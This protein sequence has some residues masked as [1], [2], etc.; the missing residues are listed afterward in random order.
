M[1]VGW[2]SWA[3]KTEGRNPASFPLLKPGKHMWGSSPWNTV[4][5]VF[6]VQ[7][8][9]NMRCIL[10][11]TGTGCF[12]SRL[13]H[14]GCISSF[15]GSASHMPPCLIL[16]LSETART[17]WPLHY[18]AKQRRR[19]KPQ[20]RVLFPQSPCVSNVGL[21]WF[22]HIFT[23]ECLSS[24]RM[25]Q[26][27][28]PDSR[29]VSDHLSAP[30]LHPPLQP[31]HPQLVSPSS[32]LFALPPIS[33]AALRPLPLCTFHSLHFQLNTRAPCA[34]LDSKPILPPWIPLSSAFLFTITFQFSAP[35]CFL[36]QRGGSW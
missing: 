30:L 23:E 5:K 8:R 22:V 4:W 13:V 31:A 15:T 16:G 27:T 10:I 36:L 21:L 18:C 1:D 29:V 11:S 6:A 34:R 7:N 14:G 28:C 26:N 35:F 25:W 32:L 12:F 9:E 20:T 24:G 33:T 2:W 17:Q 3:V 19:W